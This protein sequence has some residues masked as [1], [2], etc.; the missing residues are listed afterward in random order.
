MAGRRHMTAVS[1]T[2]AL[3]AMALLAGCG[4]EGEPLPPDPQSVWP[5]QY[6]AD[7]RP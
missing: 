2:L 5:R 6:P 3:L 4:R 7:D 1:L